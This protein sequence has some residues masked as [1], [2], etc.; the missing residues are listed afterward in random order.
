MAQG[1]VL[2]FCGQMKMEETTHKLQ[3]GQKLDVIFPHF[4]EYFSRL[5]S[6]I[7]FLTD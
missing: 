4:T 6:L 5:T 3:E 2:L 1:A 7:L